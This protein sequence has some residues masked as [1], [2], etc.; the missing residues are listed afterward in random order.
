[1][2]LSQNGPDVTGSFTLFSSRDFFSLQGVLEGGTLP[3]RRV[4]SGGV[5]ELRLLH[6]VGT[7]DMFHRM[8]GSFTFVDEYQQT[9]GG[10][11]RYTV[12]ADLLGVT[13]IP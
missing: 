8:N 2:V 7:P 3:N 1:M 9:A 6:W 5:V 4:V 10:M 13:R 12:D 11:L